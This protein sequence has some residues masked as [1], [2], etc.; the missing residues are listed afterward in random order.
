MS[1]NFL[2]FIVK[3]SPKAVDAGPDA[4]P[5][6]DPGASQSFDFNSVLAK[7]QAKSR[8]PKSDAQPATEADP[9]AL[10]KPQV[11]VVDAQSLVVADSEAPVGLP[12]VAA[13]GNPLPELSIHSRAL[14][15]GRV[16][17]TTANPKVSEE[18][19]SQFARAQ[20][21]QVL[22]LKPL[23]ASPRAT[24]NPLSPAGGLMQ[25]LVNSGA[26]ADPVVSASEDPHTPSPTQN[27]IAQKMPGMVEG[28]VPNLANAAMP[29]S[30][31][32]ARQRF[33]Q[34]ANWPGDTP[35]V[36]GAKTV[37]EKSELGAMVE[38]TTDALAPKKFRC[39]D[40]N[41]ANPTTRTAAANEAG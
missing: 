36:A 2:S 8:S 24:D 28:R 14:Q 30:A 9:V 15:V 41:R 19:L 18:S 25:R 31:L 17:L 20:G 39:A 5:E 40:A 27:A 11:D 21:G 26:V 10:A 7:E 35:P 33:I 22:D 3:A 13:N 29:Q 12:N 37:G 6:T 16:I 1:E 34:Q 4:P 23:D 38:K 32:D